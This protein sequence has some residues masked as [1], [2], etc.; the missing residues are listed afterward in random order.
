ME[1]SIEGYFLRF[2]GMISTYR[3]YVLYI[4]LTREKLQYGQVGRILY[5]INMFLIK[6]A[7]LLQL[8]RVFVPLKKRNALFWTCQAFI[9]LNFIYYTVYVCLAIFSCNPIKKGW[10]QQVYP[11]IKGS[12]LDLR[13][14]YLAG[15]IINT[16]SDLSIVILPQPVIW[17]LHLSSKKKVGLCVV[18][19]IG[20]L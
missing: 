14:A 20:L 17:R 15:A 13:A 9:W 4:Q 8:L 16:I 3:F 18:F 6:L 7:V 12:C 2:S 5:C 19:L 1:Y 10:S 11:P